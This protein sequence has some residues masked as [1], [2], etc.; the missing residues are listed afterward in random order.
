MH[1]GELCPGR[2][3]LRTALYCG[4]VLASSDSSHL[5]CLGSTA[6]PSKIRG[7]KSGRIISVLVW[8]LCGATL[9]LAITRQSLWIDEGYTVWFA[10][11]RS[12]GS[13]FS[14][15]IGSRDSSGDPQMLLYLFYMWGWVKLFG[16][17]EAVLRAANI[18]FAILFIGTM[19]WAS[20]RLLGQPNLSALFYLSPF[21]WF[22][23]NEARPYVALM[24]FSSV[25]VVALLAYLVW[26]D[27]YRVLGPWCC[28]IALLLACGTHILGVFLV[29]SVVFLTVTTIW[30]DSKFRS[31]FVRDWYRPAILCSPA[32]IALATFYIWTSTYGVNKG[33]DRPG[34]RNLGYV[35]YEFLGFGGLGPPRADI[36]DNPHLSVFAPYWP[37]MLLGAVTLFGL[38]FFLFRVR[39]PKIV[40]RLL[41]SLLV[42]VAIAQVTSM[43]D[44]SEV[45]GRHLAAFFPLF[46]ITLMLWPTRSFSPERS[47]LAVFA[48]LVALGVVWGTSDARLVFMKKYE[49]DSYRDASSIVTARANLDGGKILWAADPHAAHYYGIQVM[50][51]QRSAEIGSA[52]GLDWPIKEHAVDARNWTPKDA[53]EYVDSSSTPTILALSKR[54]IF[55]KNRGW[56]TLIQQRRPTEIARLAQF[57]IYEWHPVNTVLPHAEPDHLKPR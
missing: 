24:A 26:P 37:W 57:T 41:G 7:F 46:L 38:W 27:K 40:V 23:L 44:H 54:D 53:A 2:A 30:G 32:F 47:R 56:D 48:P 14:A 55:D 4:M 9:G 34:V 3:I 31:I 35:L 18:P 11:H 52:E 33:V 1:R 5:T 17:T 28:L 10:S 36:R 15:L 42:G 20:R 43:I 13:F 19:N 49:K 6:E 45:L 39:P 21:F 50:K 8:L 12:I 51:G 25:A 29:P 16:R 22:Y